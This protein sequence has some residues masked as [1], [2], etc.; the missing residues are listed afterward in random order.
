M[1]LLARLKTIYWRLHSRRARP[2]TVG[3]N[4]AKTLG[5][6]LV[7]WTVFLV[8]APFLVWHLESWLLAW[9]WTFQRFAPPR[10]GAVR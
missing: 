8:V 6:S 1:D 7:M 3:W 5:Q 2:A 10:A 9:G 4:L